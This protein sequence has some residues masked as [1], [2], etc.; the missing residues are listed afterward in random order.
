MAITKKVT[1]IDLNT[2]HATT[3]TLREI[4]KLINIPEERIKRY[5]REQIKQFKNYFIAFTHELIRKKGGNKHAFDNINRARGFI[6]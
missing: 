6:K 5:R 4:S 2:G 3:G 1:I